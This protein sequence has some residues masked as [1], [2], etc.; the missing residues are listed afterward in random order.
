MATDGQ[1][2]SG[3]TG[4]HGGQAFDV[5]DTPGPVEIRN[6]KGWNNKAWSKCYGRDGA[7]V[8]IYR[9]QNVYVHHNESRDG[10]VFAE[11]AGGDTS[12]IRLL[13]NQSTNEQFLTTHQ[14]NGLEIGYNTVRNSL[15]ENHTRVM[16]WIGSGG[17]FG[18][19]S[20]SNFKFHHNTIST[21]GLIWQVLPAF[22]GS[23]WI[24]HNTYEQRGVQFGIYRYADT[25]RF[26]DWWS[27]TGKDANSVSV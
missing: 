16:M 26:A 24:D 20:T 8:E 22:D 6:S 27:R 18:S 9:A 14:A 5:A 15:T 17:S 10:V 3:G 7:F 23:A 2:C 25:M 19:G 11:V 4:D 13:H 1:D 21:P 12:G